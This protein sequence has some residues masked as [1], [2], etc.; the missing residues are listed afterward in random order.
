V[1]E[2]QVRAGSL[3][4]EEADVSPIRNLI[5]RAIGTTGG[6]VADVQC[7]TVEPGDLYL[8]TTDG[9]M[10]ELSDTEILG[11]LAAAPVSDNAALAALCRQL[12]DAANAKGGADNI[13]CLLVYF[14]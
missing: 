7:L 11:M 6:V 5:T 4:R 2:E 13:T 1:V 10:R 14:P 3:T 12:V 9:L 8:L